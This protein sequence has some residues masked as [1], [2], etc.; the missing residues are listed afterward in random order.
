[1]I[2]SETTLIEDHSSSMTPSALLLLLTPILRV[3]FSRVLLDT[4]QPTQSTKSK[5]GI[6]VMTEYW[7]AHFDNDASLQIP[8]ELVDSL[9]ILRRLEGITVPNLLESQVDSLPP[10][11]GADRK[12][13]GE[14]EMVVEREEGGNDSLEAP[15]PGQRAS[16]PIV[17]Q[18]EDSFVAHSRA[19]SLSIYDV[20]LIESGLGTDLDSSM[21][22]S[23]RRSGYNADISLSQ[24]TIPASAFGRTVPPPP[25][26]ERLPSPTFPLPVVEVEQSTSKKRKAGVALNSKG[27]S[28]ELLVLSK[29]VR[30]LIWLTEARSVENSEVEDHSAVVVAD[31]PAPESHPTSSQRTS[32]SLVSPSSPSKLTGFRETQN[33]RNLQNEQRPLEQLRHLT[34]QSDLS[35]LNT[36]SNYGSERGN[37]RVLAEGDRGRILLIRVK[38]LFMVSLSFSYF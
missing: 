2:L 7:K 19:S 18:N 17:G 3:A 24:A 20:V 31:D 1:M 25:R 4:T 21:D 13:G 27:K 29:C 10:V 30:M 32:I 5:T 6:E 15:P 23:E 22:R 11:R 14:M 28:S 26:Q 9:S 33:Q 12:E 35:S 38:L 36:L 34:Q 8:T 37:L 16:S